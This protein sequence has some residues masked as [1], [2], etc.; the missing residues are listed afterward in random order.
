MLYFF[1]NNNNT[2]VGCLGLSYS[3]KKKKMFKNLTV[4]GWV[5]TATLKWHYKRVTLELVEFSQIPV[6]Q[7]VENSR[8]VYNTMDKDQHLNLTSTPLT[9]VHSYLQKFGLWRLSTT[10][11]FSH[12]L[13]M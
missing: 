5:L 1:N 3:K 8:N 12:Q 10:L 4:Q 7:Q 2:P 13:H 9:S 6:W 11:L